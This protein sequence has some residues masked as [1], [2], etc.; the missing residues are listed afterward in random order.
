MPRYI[1]MHSL[2]CLTR[3]GAEQLAVRLAAASGIGAQRIQVNMVEGKMLV[4]LEAPDREA[5]ETWFRAQGFHYDWLMRVEWEFEE[6][7]LK[8]VT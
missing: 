8:P 3:Q 5:V 1:S 4:E 2:A 6:G 7:K